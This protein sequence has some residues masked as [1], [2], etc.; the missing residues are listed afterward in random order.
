MGLEAAAGAAPGA[1]ATA[2]RLRVESAER[3]SDDEIL[4]H[5]RNALVTD[6]ALADIGIHVGRTGRQEPARVPEQVHGAIDISAADGIVT[7][8]GRVPG[9][10]RKR[11]VGVLAW[12]V[13]GSRNVVND[14]ARRNEFQRL[15]LVA[16]P[17]TLGDLRAELDDHAQRLVV[18]ELAHDLVHT[19]LPELR[20]HL[21][22]V[23]P[24]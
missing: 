1:L 7:L 19:P 24:E 14:A 20:R 8:D 12:W 15:V 4:E 17:K 22:S 16:P 11:L 2:G 23:L 5:V 9:L 6:P 13:P 10:G 18:G 21:A 3:Q